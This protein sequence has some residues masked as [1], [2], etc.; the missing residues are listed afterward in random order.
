MHPTRFLA[1]RLIEQRGEERA[2]RNQPSF[3]STDAQE[4]SLPACLGDLEPEFVI[5][6]QRFFG[7][8]FAL[9]GAS[10]LGE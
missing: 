3:G 10:Q 5:L 9:A 8:G 7:K 4:P 2:R 6:G 1:H